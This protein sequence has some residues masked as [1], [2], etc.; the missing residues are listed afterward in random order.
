M[1]VKLEGRAAALTSEA[2]QHM[3]IALA[4]VD[5]KDLWRVLVTFFG[6]NREEDPCKFLDGAPLI[7]C[8]LDLT[9]TESDDD[10]SVASEAAS[11][12]SKASSSSKT[13]EKKPIA[14]KPCN[15]I[16]ADLIDN[17]NETQGFLPSSVDSLHTTGIPASLH[18]SHSD[19]QTSKG[20][21]LYMCRHK[22]C[23]D[24]PYLGDL[25]TCGSHIRCIHL[26]VCLMCPYCPN[27]HFYNS[28]G[29]R[30]H[31]SKKHSSVPWYGAPTTDKSVQAQA[32]L[33]AL[34][35][36]PS[37]HI[38]SLEN[39]SSTPSSQAA[40]TKTSTTTHSEQ[41]QS[42]I[43]EIPTNV[44]F[45]QA[46]QPK[47]KKWY[48]GASTSSGG[49]AST[50]KMHAQW[51]TKL[52]KSSEVPLLTPPP[53]PQPEEELSETLPYEITDPED[54]TD[55]SEPSVTSHPPTPSDQAVAWASLLAP[56]D[57][58]QWDFSVNKK[59]HLVSHHAKPK[60]QNPMTPSAITSIVAP[61]LGYARGPTSP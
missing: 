61:E 36:D 55:V 4:G 17:I 28:G 57:L 52:A 19:R 54:T 15:I 41:I 56:S 34:S 11:T 49:V 21:S 10:T 33:D 51:I 59:G 27:R 13:T 12:Q 20:A 38:G 18:M 7:K 29:W 23:S 43:K 39:T 46:Q 25:P 9:D 50:S 40:P 8:P 16:R 22:D 37:A 35:T 2:L 24:N 60:V 53:L 5:C 31:M 48:G 6:F 26:G 14:I 1:S 58:R 45:P 3:M 32:M 44:Q 42:L 30:D 47:S